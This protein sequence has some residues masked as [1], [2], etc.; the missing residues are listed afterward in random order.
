MPTAADIV[1]QIESF[2]PADRVK[3]IDM[4]IRDTLKSDPDIEEIWIRE[5]EARWDSFICGDVESISLEDIM[6]KYQGK[7]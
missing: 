7:R 5:V 2:T 3:I 6:S 4:V 1:R